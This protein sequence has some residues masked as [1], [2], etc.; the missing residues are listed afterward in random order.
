MLDKKEIQAVQLRFGLSL[1]RILD[2][3]KAKASENKL[4]GLDN[5]KLIDSYGKLESSSGLRK[6]TLIDVTVGKRNATFTT[7]AAILD[8]LGMTL[9]EFGSYYDSISEEEIWEYKKTIEKSKKE[10]K[11]R[12]T[13]VKPKSI[14]KSVAKKKKTKK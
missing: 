8:A 13:G 4:E 7:I 9:T 1:K 3:N 14:S 11:G 12:K 2:K 6:A 10:R 5:P